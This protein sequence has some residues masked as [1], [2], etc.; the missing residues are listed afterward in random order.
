MKHPANPVQEP[1]VQCTR[2]TGFFPTAYAREEII[3]KGEVEK[4]PVFPVQ[5][6]AGSCTGFE[7]SSTGEASSPR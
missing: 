3:I 1:D 6:T 7:A 5:S 4:K 2:F